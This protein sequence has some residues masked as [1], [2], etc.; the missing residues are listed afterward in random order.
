MIT[1]QARTSCAAMYALI[2]IVQITL[3]GTSPQVLLRFVA[4]RR[5][6]SLEHATTRGGRGT[7]E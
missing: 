7:L 2:S 3:T 1:D 5:T 4:T 6:E